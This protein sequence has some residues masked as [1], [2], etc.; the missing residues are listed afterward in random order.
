MTAYPVE[1]IQAG[2][3]VVIPRHQFAQ[4]FGGAVETEPDIRYIAGQHVVFGGPTQ[5]S[6]KTQLCFDL[7]EYA[8]TPDCPAFVFVSKPG[9]AVTKHYAKLYKWRVV[10]EWPPNKQLK[11]Y[12]GHKYS[13]YVIWPVFGDLHQDRQKVYN[14]LSTAVADLYGKTATSKKPKHGILVF[15]DTRDKEKVV[16][17]KYEMTTVVTMAGAMGLGAWCFVQKGSQQGDTALAAYPAAAHCFLFHDPTL[18]GREYYA[19][20]GGVD[21]QYIEWVLPQLKKRQCL[22]I[23]R[24]S[25]AVYIV[26]N[27]SSQGRIGLQ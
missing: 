26:D 18:S 5:I 10:R 14:V 8:A 22:Y 16:G 23:G 13:G 19:G 24:N 2:L 12:F 21:P 1:R 17:L 6:G 20:I 9:D 15:D 4:M 27:D 25:Q 7:L 11:E 3:P